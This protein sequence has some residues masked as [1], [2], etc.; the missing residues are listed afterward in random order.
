M[1]EDYNKLEKVLKELNYTPKVSQFDGSITWI[2]VKST[3]KGKKIKLRMI[4]KVSFGAVSV[5][6][7]KDL[8]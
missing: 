7:E 6:D 5:D 2:N 4:V 1:I 8:T 3:K